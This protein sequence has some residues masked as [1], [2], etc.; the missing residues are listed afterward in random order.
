MVHLVTLPERH[1]LY[2][3][4]T[5]KGMWRIKQHKLPPNSLLEAYNY[6][7]DCL[8]KKPIISKNLSSKGV[9]PFNISI[10][11]DRDGSKSDA[12]NTHKEMKVYSDSLATDGKVGAAVILIRA[13]NPPYILHMHLG[14]ENEHTVHKSELVG[15]ILGVQLISTEKRGSTFTSL[16]V[17]N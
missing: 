4:V 17:N 15:I 9:P 1:P 13:G 14:S 16:E 7:I 8:E 10:I 3:I 12:N 2:N 6:D 11:K 5:H